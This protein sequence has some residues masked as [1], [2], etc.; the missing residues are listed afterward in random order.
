MANSAPRAQLAENRSRSGIRP[1]RRQVGRACDA[2]RLR[3]I[4][5]DDASPCANCRGRGQQCSNTEA[6]RTSTLSQAHEEIDRLRLKVLDLERELQRH[7]GAHTNPETPFSLHSQQVVANVEATATSNIEVHF[8]TPK[9][10]PWDGALLRPARSPHVAWFGPS[11]LYF[12]IHRLGVFLST[13]VE[14]AQPDHMLLRSTS[15][16]AVPAQSRTTS[17]D[18]SHLLRP[19]FNGNKPGVYLN[20]IQEEYF[21]NLFW[22][23]YHTSLYAIV[24]EAEFK[25]E[26]QA[27]YL[28]VP[29]GYTRKPSALVDIVVAM[30]M[31][32]MASSLPSSH[33]GNIV[34]GNDA[35]T[36]GRWHYRRAQ[37]LLAGEM[38]SPT[39]STLQC[40][41][42][43]AVYVCGASFH[44]MADSICGQAVRIAY[45]LGL[46]IDPPLDT[47][48]K[49][50][51]VRRRLWWAVYV[52]DSKV[53]MKLGRP[54]LLHGSFFMPPFPDDQLGASML[55]GS[56]FAPISGDATWLSFSL[57]HLKLFKT[58]RDAHTTL[59]SHDVGL[60]QHKT[61]WDD[62]TSLAKVAESLEPH[63]VMIERWVQ[64]LPGALKNSRVNNGRILSTDGSA[65]VIEQYAPLWLQRQRLLLEMEYHHMS[66]NLYRPF[67]SFKRVPAVGSLLETV[68]VESINHAIELSKIT[69]QALSST[70]IL[71]GWHE[72][73]Q[74]QWNSAITLA[75][76]ILANP[77]HSAV[78]SAR[79]AMDLALSVFST[80][81][82]SFELAKNA[83]TVVR[84]LCTKIDGLI[85]ASSQHYGQKEPAELSTLRIGQ[86]V[87]VANDF[88]SELT[89]TSTSPELL[90]Q[91]PEFDFT[92]M[93]VG[94]D[95]WANIDMLGVGDINTFGE[96]SLF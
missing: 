67:I 55:S 45:M 27:L 90:T 71:D 23:S 87:E 69:Q 33:Q 61:I 18:A 78:V 11:S 30:C 60:G 34:E 14:H 96:S 8:V 86:E 84:M 68:A 28:D 76:F 75:G 2:C 50:L 44:N 17:E 92:E 46:H 70:A 20:P 24:D 5:C 41:L 43:S 65:L 63:T 72:A 19:L 42:L 57:H 79:S 31:Q 73:F 26:Y 88:A 64:N 51:Q 52:L 7:R 32:Y 21:V 74:W 22:Q 13:D 91:F 95:F 83:E 1:K 4:K 38:E 40:H 89:H 39:I 9:N 94:V 29:H 62:P 93:A 25:K 15:G 35:T 36:A 53:G 59:Y 82:Q 56:T 80:F 12:F 3:R 85:S 58:M 49:E 54:F 77:R 47:P 10:K 66:V 16:S 37:T 6:T 81:G 48:E